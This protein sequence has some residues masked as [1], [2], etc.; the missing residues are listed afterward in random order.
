MVVGLDRRVA[1]ERRYG[2][3]GVL[4]RL[5]E[6]LLG[7]MQVVLGLVVRG[8]AGDAL[9]EEALLTVEDLLLEGDVV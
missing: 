9:G 3:L 7:G 1:A 8:L 4:L 6:G 2:R 5:G